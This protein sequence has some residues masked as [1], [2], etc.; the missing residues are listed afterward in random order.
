MKSRR[1][2]WRVPSPAAELGARQRLLVEQ[3]LGEHVQI[4]LVFLQQPRAL[5]FASSSSRFT[6]SSITSLVSWD[7]P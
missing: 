2:T 6:S 7:R 3:L 1:Q 4:L 5:W